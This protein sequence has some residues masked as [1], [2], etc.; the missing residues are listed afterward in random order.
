MG[1]LKNTTYYYY[2]HTNKG[3]TTIERKIIEINLK[4]YGYK[5][6]KT[7]YYELLTDEQVQFYL[8]NPNASVEEVRNCQLNQQVVVTEDLQNAIDSAIMELKYVFTNSIKIDNLD[9]AAA[10]ADFLKQNNSL[11]LASVPDLMD[12][13]ESRRI[14]AEFATS[15]LASKT[16]YTQGVNALN[17]ATSIVEIEEILMDY[18]VRFNSL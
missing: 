4:F 12:N 1:I 9:F 8:A 7:N 5:E 17:N 10:V 2:F 16:L 13:S 11:T 18:K 14:I 6:G 15:Y 3:V